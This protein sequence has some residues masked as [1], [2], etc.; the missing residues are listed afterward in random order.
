VEDRS[1]E[2]AESNQELTDQIESLENGGADTGDLEDR[3]E[4][5]ESDAA[6]AQSQVE[7]LERRIEQLDSGGSSSP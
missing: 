2:T 4:Q 6:A 7:A 3:I 1:T 5:A